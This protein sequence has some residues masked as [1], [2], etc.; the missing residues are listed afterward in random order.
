MLGVLAT[1]ALHTLQNEARYSI[2]GTLVW[3]VEAVS[4][5]LCSRRGIRSK[6]ELIVQEHEHQALLA[7]RA[8]VFGRA[9][10][11]MVLLLQLAAGLL[12]KCAHETAAE[13]LSP[14]EGGI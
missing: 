5:T 6:P 7:K 9:L 11:Q 12:C 8:G 3:S 13:R 4:G 2:R 10:L 14:V 1:C